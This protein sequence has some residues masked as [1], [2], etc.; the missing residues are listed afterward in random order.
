MTMI[1]TTCAP[2]RRGRSVRLLTGGQSNLAETAKSVRERFKSVLVGRRDTSSRAILQC[3]DLGL[4]R[5]TR[6]EIGSIIGL[7]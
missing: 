2:A 4:R 3:Q 6:L 5:T 7:W 1:A